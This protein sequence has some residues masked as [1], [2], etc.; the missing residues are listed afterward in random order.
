MVVEVT[1]MTKSVPRRFYRCP[2]R[3]YITEYRW[4]LARHLYKVH[5]YYKKD[6]AQIAMENEYRLSPM[7]YRKRDLLRRYEEEQ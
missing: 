7:Y 1:K 3:G 5:Y 6:I 4:V 2:E